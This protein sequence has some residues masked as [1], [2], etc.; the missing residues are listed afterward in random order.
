[1]IGH[2]KRDTKYHHFDRNSQPV[3]G[4][5]VGVGIIVEMLARHSV[6]ADIVWETKNA[7][8]CVTAYVVPD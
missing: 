5:V 7:E 6:G 8:L 4:G 1:M 2:L 3:G